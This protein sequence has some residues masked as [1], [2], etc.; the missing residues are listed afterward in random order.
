MAA[1]TVVGGGL[2]G[3]VASI[4]CAEAGAKVHLYEAHA[5]LGGRAR[6]TPPPFIATTAPTCSPVTGRCGRGWPSGP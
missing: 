3:L 2:A 1:I 5:T 4:A 6:S